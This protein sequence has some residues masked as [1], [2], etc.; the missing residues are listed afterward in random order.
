MVWYVYIYRRDM[1]FKELQRKSIRL[2][3][4]RC[5]LQSNTLTMREAK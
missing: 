2:H 3:V 1:L 4:E 5:R